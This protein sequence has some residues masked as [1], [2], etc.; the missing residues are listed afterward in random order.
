MTSPYPFW[1][2]GDRFNVKHCLTGTKTHVTRLSW[3][4]FLYN[5]WESIELEKMYSYTYTETEH[6]WIHPRVD[7]VIVLQT[8]QSRCNNLVCSNSAP[9]PAFWNIKKSWKWFWPT[10]SYIQLGMVT[11]SVTQVFDWNLR[12]HLVKMG[13]FG[14]FD[15]SRAG[16]HVQ[17][18]YRR[19][20]RGITHNRNRVVSN[21]KST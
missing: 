6:N 11:K 14:Y 5:A 2:T 13:L 12:K 1:E 17:T 20:V 10:R 3:L 8:D 21:W 4:S 19:T 7:F 18:K 16:L 15:T 9:L